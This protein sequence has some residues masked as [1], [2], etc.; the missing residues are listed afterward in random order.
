M[1]KTYKGWELMKA[2]AEGEIKDE[3]RFKDKDGAQVK[4]NGYNLKLIKSGENYMC[5]IS[6]LYFANE[7]FELIE[8][9]IDIDNIKEI[10]TDEICDVTYYINDLIKAVK[11]IDKRVK[12]LED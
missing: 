2:I 7:V 8:D 10:K 4:W 1:G 11:Q 6:D 3:S 9:E 5:T 12:K